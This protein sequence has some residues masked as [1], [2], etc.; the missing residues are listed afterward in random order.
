MSDAER[1]VHAAGV[2]AAAGARG[3]RDWLADQLAN[4]GVG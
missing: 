4:A 1:R 2:R 3:P